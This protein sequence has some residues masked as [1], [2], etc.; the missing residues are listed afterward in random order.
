M[1][2]ASNIPIAY[3]DWFADWKKRIQSAQIKAAL[4]VSRELLLLYWELGQDIAAKQ[5]T[6]PWGEGLIPRFSKDLKAAFPHLT[7]F[8]HQNLFYIRKWHHFFTAR[9]LNQ[10][11]RKLRDNW[12]AYLCSKLLHNY[13]HLIISNLHFLCLCL[14][15][16]TKLFWI[17]VKISEYILTHTLPESLKNLLP[18][19][20]ALERELDE[21]FQIDATQP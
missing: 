1:E 7:R 13:N 6:T 9:N 19:T 14:G 17:N 8:S 15:R 18:S 21:G 16:T 3:P 4:H 12:E 11:S 5:E 10:L 2:N 20:E